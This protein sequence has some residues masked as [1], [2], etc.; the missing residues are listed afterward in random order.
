MKVLQL[1]PWSSLANR[2]SH[3]LQTE[4]LAND[5]RAS[6]VLSALDDFF[7][8]IIL[9]FVKEMLIPTKWLKI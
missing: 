5:G 1:V 3:T 2:K 8:V 9:H 6:D 4:E 7:T